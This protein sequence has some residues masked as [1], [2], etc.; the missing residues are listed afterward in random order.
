MR[1]GGGASERSRSRASAFVTLRDEAGR[2]VAEATLS[3]L[4]PVS[5]PKTDYVPQPAPVKTPLDVCMY[6]FPGWENDAKWDCI[7]NIAPVRKPLLAATP[8]QSASFLD[9]LTANGY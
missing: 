9:I 7:R 5:A 2:A 3:L 8:E 4:P 6:Y 1:S